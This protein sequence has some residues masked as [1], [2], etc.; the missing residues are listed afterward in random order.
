LRKFVIPV[1][2]VTGK[3]IVTLPT[4]ATRQ[5]FVKP[6]DSILLDF[7]RILMKI[8]F[9]VRVVKFTLE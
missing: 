1:T 7:D 6:D 5:R 9:R 8:F 4:V 2:N 3:S